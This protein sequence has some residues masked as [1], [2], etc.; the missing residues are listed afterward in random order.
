[1]HVNAITEA[2][3]GIAE[4]VAV[5]DAELAAAGDIDLSVEAGPVAVDII[6][7]EIDAHVERAI[8]G[9]GIGATHFNAATEHQGGGFPG[10]NIH[11]VRKVVENQVGAIRHEGGAVQS[12]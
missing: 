1:M 5:V 12:D 6:A 2:Q 10:R 7:D 3:P 9:S 8:H 4:T 11:V